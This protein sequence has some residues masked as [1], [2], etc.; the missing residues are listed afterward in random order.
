MKHKKTRIASFIAS[1]EGEQMG[2][3]TIVLGGAGDP[4]VDP[5]STTNNGNCTNATTAGCERSTNKGD[6]KN[7][8]TACSHS[9]NGGSCN[10]GWVPEK[11]LHPI[12]SQTC[13]TN[14]QC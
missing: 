5:L 12:V 3:N 7:N 13:A 10:N 11:D 9:K 14:I 4:P 2:A 6:C 8:M 1:L